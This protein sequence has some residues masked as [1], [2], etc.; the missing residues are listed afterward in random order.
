MFSKTTC[1][2]SSRRLFSNTIAYGALVFYI[3]TNSTDVRVDMETLVL[4]T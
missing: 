2:G 3:V 4:N 1:M